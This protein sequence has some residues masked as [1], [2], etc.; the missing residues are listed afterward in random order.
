MKS[1]Q[2]IAT[3]AALT[4]W[5]IGLVAVQTTRSAKAATATQPERIRMNA[6]ARDWPSRRAS[7]RLPSEFCGRSDP[8]PSSG[9]TRRRTAGTTSAASPTPPLSAARSCALARSR[10]Y[11]PRWALGADGLADETRN[12]AFGDRHGPHRAAGRVRCL[13]NL[14]PL[15]GP[16]AP[17]LFISARAWASRG[18]NLPI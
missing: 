8:P 14:E 18:A 2:P 15:A 1:R 16:T 7:R 10:I 5:L 3:P 11:L 6:P 4:A 12:L 13:Y 9:K 17:R